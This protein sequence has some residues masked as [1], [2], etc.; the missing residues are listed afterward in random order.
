MTEADFARFRE[1]LE[2]KCGILLGADKRYLVDT[3]LARVLR[4]ES[5]PDMGTLVKMLTSPVTPPGWLVT[6]VVDAMTTNETLWFRDTYPF[7]ALKSTFLPQFLS[8]G[9]RSIRI[10]SAACSSGQEPYSISMTISEF[11]KENR[12]NIN[13]TIMATDISSRMIETARQGLYDDLSLGRGLSDTR[14]QAF[15]IQ[16]PNGWR[17]KPEIRSR[18]QFSQLNLLDNYATLGRFDL[19]YCRNVLIYFSKDT[20][21][22]IVAGMSDVLNDGGYLVLGASESINQLTDRYVLE[23]LPQGGLVHKKVR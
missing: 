9:K 3:R 15:F 11:N 20:K 12:V 18:V 14:R 8:A 21:T 10:W 4:E 19:I 22:R 5:I 1:F 2:R 16:E 6:R 17:V 7:A 23:R 13:A